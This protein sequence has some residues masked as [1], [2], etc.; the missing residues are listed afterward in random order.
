M[1]QGLD[2]RKLKEIPEGSL[3]SAKVLIAQI[4][5]PGNTP[6]EGSI[7]D[8]E[9]YPKGYVIGLRSDP[10]LTYSHLKGKLALAGPC[11]RKKTQT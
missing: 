3:Y 11:F 5:F 2:L 8:I 1:Y 7:P 10:P 9:I 4:Y 6:G